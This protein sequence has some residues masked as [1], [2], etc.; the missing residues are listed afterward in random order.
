MDEFRSIVGVN[1]TASWENP[2]QKRPL[3][4]FPFVEADTRL[5]I[6][7]VAVSN[8]INIF[9]KKITAF[10]TRWRDVC[11]M[12]RRTFA[13]FFQNFLDGDAQAMMRH[14]PGKLLQVCG[15]ASG[16][17]GA[18]LSFATRFLN[19]VIGQILTLGILSTIDAPLLVPAILIFDLVNKKLQYYTCQKPLFE[20]VMRKTPVLMK[21]EGLLMEIIQ[22]ME[23]TSILAADEVS[24]KPY[25]A[26]QITY[27]RFEMV[28]M[29]FGQIYA[30]FADILAKVRSQLIP[31]LL[32]LNTMGEDGTINVASFL[33]IQQMSDK[34]SVTYFFSLNE[35]IYQMYTECQPE[36]K[37]FMETRCKTPRGPRDMEAHVDNIPKANRILACENVRFNFE[38][39]PSVGLHGISLSCC[40][41]SMNGL[42]G[43][44]GSGKSTL[45]RLL[46]GFYDVDSGGLLLAGENL[47]MFTMSSRSRRL[48]LIPQENFMLQE[49]LRWNLTLGRDIDEARLLKVVETVS[50]KSFLQKS[51]E[52]FEVQLGNAGNA[53]NLSG[54]E[55]QRIGIARALLS[56]P[57]V[58]LLDEAT[59]AL[60]SQSA[61]L[62][63]NA[64]EQRRVQDTIIVLAI[65]HRLAAI[66]MSDAIFVFHDGELV[67]QGNHESLQAGNGA[68]VYAKLVRA[69]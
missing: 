67:E 66:A 12:Q 2:G 29:F 3:A 42:V 69:S 33:L 28:Q 50:M 30:A 10:A 32:V 51:A 19:E 53:V 47:N 38:M 22:K 43:A 40:A 27:L 4:G 7:L 49:T 64:I 16:S 68:G 61:L 17:C 23:A 9:F 44:S 58:L 52:G 13:N 62:V 41:G 20:M 31:L 60:D 25:R 39:N 14:Q 8:F 26:N 46:A 59:A 6:T 54:G 11:F 57:A 21:E 48:C 65:A 45:I 1:L 35:E 56:D 36:V 18:L 15:R 34:I 24:I 37:F 5:L 63:T 55:R